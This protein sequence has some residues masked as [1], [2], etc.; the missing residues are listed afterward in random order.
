LDDHI[1]KTEIDRACRHV[2]R[3][4][5][6]TGILLGNLRDEDHLKNP[7]IGG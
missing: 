7:G 5:V 3:R 6:H 4:E 2:E 1:K